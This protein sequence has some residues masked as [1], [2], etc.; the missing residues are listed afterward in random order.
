MEFFQAFQTISDYL[1]EFITLS[2]LNSTKII[3]QEIQDKSGFPFCI[4]YVICNFRRKNSRSRKEKSC[5]TN[6]KEDITSSLEIFIAAVFH[7]QSNTMLVAYYLIRRL[8]KMEFFQAFQTISDY[9]DEF[10][11]L[12]T[13]NSTKII[14]QEIQDKSG[15]PFCIGYVIC[16]FRRKNSRSR[17]EK[18]CGTNR[19]EENKRGVYLRPIFFDCN[20]EKGEDSKESVYHMLRGK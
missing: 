19:K 13:L 16:N 3:M 20:E 1:D 18:S 10:I 2:T 17:K 4:G 5:G 6:R 14:M 8:L 15:F 9:L 12:S 7:V 11:T